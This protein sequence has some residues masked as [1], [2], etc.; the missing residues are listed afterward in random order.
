[1]A[2]RI[3]SWS[4]AQISAAMSHENEEIARQQGAR[5]YAYSVG[6]L[7]PDQLR[8]FRENQAKVLEQHKKK[9]EEAI[10]DGTTKSADDASKKAKDD[11]E[12][13]L[14]E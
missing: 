10:L 1:M 4:R 13:E 9:Q 12:T 11:A 5:K 6:A 14:G 7:T 8:E 3:E 2:E